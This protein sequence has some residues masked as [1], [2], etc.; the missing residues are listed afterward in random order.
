VKK[1]TLNESISDDRFQLQ[2]P[3]GSELVKVGEA[4]PGKQQ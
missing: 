2:Q 3:P 4:G 1:V